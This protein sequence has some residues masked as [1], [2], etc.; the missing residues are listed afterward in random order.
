MAAMIGLLA[1]LGVAAEAL[2]LIGIAGTDGWLVAR[3]VRITRAAAA[4][5]DELALTLRRVYRSVAAESILVTVA[6]EVE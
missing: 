2:Y 1:L 5:D 3:Q 4:G 6:A